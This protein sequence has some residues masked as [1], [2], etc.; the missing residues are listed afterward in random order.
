MPAAPAGPTRPLPRPSRHPRP[1]RSPARPPAASPR[2]PAAAGGT[3]G[4]PGP[5]PVRRGPPGRPGSRGFLCSR[6]YLLVYHAQNSSAVDSRTRRR[7]SKSSSFTH[8]TAAC[9]PDPPGPYTTVGILVSR[10]PPA[11]LRPNT[12]GDPMR[13]PPS[14]AGAARRGGANFGELRHDEV[15]RI[16]LLGTSVN[17]AKEENRGT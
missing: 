6:P 7:T 12:S 17:R 16:H 11:A 14:V 3:R 10:L 4:V 9:A 13:P 5:E 1:R 2:S 15:R 8:S